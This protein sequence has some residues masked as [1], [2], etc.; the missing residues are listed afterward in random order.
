MI[1]F[2]I[3]GSPKALKRHK[4]YRGG[5]FNVNVDPS[6]GDKEDFLVMAMANRPKS[7]FR[8]PLEV[9]MIFFFPRPK[10]HF[11]ARGAL[12]ASAPYWYTPKPDLDNLIK[13]IFDALESVY[14]HNDSYIVNSD[15]K[16]VYGP[17]PGVYIEITPAQIIDFDVMNAS[18][19]IHRA[20]ECVD[21][22]GDADG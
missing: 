22:V 14:W 12:K 15:I 20:H 11:N 21:E 8:E 18:G 7:P 16:K 17:N 19:N 1:S 10:A 4:T 2:F 3:P 6:K 9:R 5:K 13:F